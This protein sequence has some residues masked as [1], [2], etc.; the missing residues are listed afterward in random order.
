MAFLYKH[1]KLILICLASLAIG[2]VA[3][4]M[5]LRE[6]I[7]VF[8]IEEIFFQHPVRGVLLFCLIFSLGNLLYIPGWIFLAGA[9]LGLGKEW[10]GMVTYVAA[11]VSC[12]VSFFLVFSIGGNALRSIEHKYARKLFS[13][14][15]DRPI[16]SISMLRLIFQTVPA[17]NYAL[18]LS[19]VR[20]RH[21]L[22]GTIIGLPIPIFVYCYFFELIFDNVLLNSGN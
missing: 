13:Q 5:G 6:S 20:F 8:K 17:L 18:A 22:T 11:T 21:Y 9:V 12:T 7:S 16:F 2:L 4:F 1:K 15:D 10:G 19:Q 14:L 3:E